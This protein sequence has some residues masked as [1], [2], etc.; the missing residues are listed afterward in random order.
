MDEEFYKHLLEK[1]NKVPNI[2]PNSHIA[3]WALAVV[4]LMFPEQ[5]KKHFDSVA[6]L[7]TA[8]AELEEQLASI[9]QFSDSTAFQNSAETAATFFKQLP[10]LYRILNTD[11][12]AIYEGDPAA[13][14]EFEVIRSY[15]GLFAISLYRIAH[16]LCRLGVP[17]IPRI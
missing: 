11:I 12:K 4:H 17:L 13:F 10:E 16:Q 14:S 6:D 5:S 1:Q 8:F 2:P 3:K 7:K 15:P 9:L